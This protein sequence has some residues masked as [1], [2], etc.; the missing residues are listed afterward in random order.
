[1]EGLDLGAWVPVIAAGLTLA[2][3]VFLFFVNRRTR[4]TQQQVNGMKMHELAE[5]ERRGA[6][7]E[8]MRT[9]PPPIGD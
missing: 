9:G 1:M 4:K 2:N 5:A 7:H 8:R 6:R 3:T